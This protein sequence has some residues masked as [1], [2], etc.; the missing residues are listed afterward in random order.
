MPHLVLDSLSADYG[1]DPV[2]SDVGL[3]V[4]RGEIVS[5]IGP[6]GSGKSTLLRVL[7]GL[8]RPRAGTVEVAGT[9][10]DYGSD[11]ALRKV[12]E[13]F[14]IVF[15]QYNLFQN[16]TALRNVT[17]APTV[18]KGRPAGEVEA[19]ARALLAKVGLSHR[20]EAYPDELS[21]G[22]Q[23]RV[24]IARALALKPDI[25]LLDEVT[26][27][28]DPELVSEVLDTIRLLAADGMTMLIVSHEMA[29]V[30]EI[31]SKV[32]FMADGRVV[33]TGP[34]AQIFDAPQTERCADFVRRILRH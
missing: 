10:V 8:L 33:E 26:S 30:R 17:V 4:E 18:V 5:I 19:E 1:R 27:A 2:L 23:Q 32:V 21:G 16:M 28:L 7:V 12:R 31:S 34:P 6:S 11:A 14:A 29:F 15:Q 20:V 22:Q 24:A 25:L 9:P 3:S 13:R